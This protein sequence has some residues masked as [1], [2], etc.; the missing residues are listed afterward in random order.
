MN[1]HQEGAVNSHLLLF[2]DEFKQFQKNV[3]REFGTGDIKFNY[4]FSAVTAGNI[5]FPLT[6]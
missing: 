4:H 6:E 5:Y 3:L 1:Q 2:N